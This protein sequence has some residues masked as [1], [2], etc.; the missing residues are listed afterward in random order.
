MSLVVGGVGCVGCVVSVEHADRDAVR[1]EPHLAGGVGAVLVRAQRVEL[2]RIHLF[3]VRAAEYAGAIGPVREPIG[4][5]YE[6]PLPGRSFLA[7]ARYSV[8]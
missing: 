7:S 3:D 8:R 1:Q 2:G 5:L 4:D 6:Y